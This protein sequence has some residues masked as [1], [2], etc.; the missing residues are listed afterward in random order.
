MATITSQ[1][2]DQ[3]G[4]NNPTLTAVSGGGDQWLN[5]GSEFVAIK[6]ASGSDL[7]VTFTA[8]TT[9]F[10]SPTYGPATKSN[11]TITLASGI[12]GYIGPFETGA[13][14]DAS[15][16][17]QITYSASTSVSIAILTLQNN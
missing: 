12:T 6:N 13:F 9:S 15:G 16:Y 2:I 14:N 7:T 17:C 5:S 11:A 1:N 8:Q 4:L 10:D 3:T